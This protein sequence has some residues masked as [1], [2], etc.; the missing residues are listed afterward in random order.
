MTKR[1]ILYIDMDNVL[2]DFESGLNRVPDAIRAEFHGR[3]D[4]IPGI[5]GLMDP[6]E[7]AVEAYTE[8]SQLFDTYI[9]GTAPWENPTA[10][11]DKVIWVQRY[12]GN[13]AR[14]RL[15]LSHH[16]NL[17]RGHFLVDDREKNGASDFEGEHIKFLSPMFETWERVREYL[18][19]NS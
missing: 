8:L 1:K 3:P 19:E 2:V 16:K 18:R 13:P 11:S 6:R 10:W 17:N 12:L 5:F 9:L 4:E 15:I 14:K 7:G